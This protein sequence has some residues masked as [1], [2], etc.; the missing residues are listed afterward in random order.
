MTIHVADG[1]LFRDSIAGMDMCKTSDEIVE[2]KHRLRHNEM[3]LDYLHRQVSLD[4][5]SGGFMRVCLTHGPACTVEQRTTAKE[6]RHGVH[7]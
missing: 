6:A 1:Y 7:F 2:S 3:S 5:G 4:C